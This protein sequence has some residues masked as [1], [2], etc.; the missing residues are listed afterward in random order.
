MSWTAPKT[1]SVGDLLTA[2]DMNTYVRDNT[3]ILPG[4]SGKITSAGTITSGTGFSVSAHTTG[5]YTIT[6]TT[7][8]SATPLV[9]VTLAVPLLFYKSAESASGFTLTAQTASGTFTDAGFDFWAR[10]TI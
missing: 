4:V 1:W 10:A 7:A 9:I 2:G 6:Y 3:T 8:F 5:N